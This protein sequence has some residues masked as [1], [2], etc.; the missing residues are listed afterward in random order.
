MPRDQGP[1]SGVRSAS[2][3]GQ[4]VDSKPPNLTVRVAMPTGLCGFSGTSL[5]DIPDA[6]R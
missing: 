5:S 2:W 4:I 6:D 1:E 3:V